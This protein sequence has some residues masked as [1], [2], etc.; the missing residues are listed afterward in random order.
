MKNVEQAEKMSNAPGFVAALDQSGGSTP[1]ALGLYGVDETQYVNNTQM[2]DLIHHMRCR[3]IQSAAFTGD[4][5]IGAILFENTIDREVSGLRVADFLWQEKQIVPFLKVDKGLAYKNKGVQLLKPMP[6]LDVLLMRAKAANIFGTKMRSVINHANLAGI[7]DIVEQQF[8]VANQILSHDLVPI[9]EPEV[10]ISSPDKAEAE[11]ML[12]ESL[13]L[14]LNDLKA[15]DKVILKL[16]LPDQ[17]NHYASLSSHA[18]IM[19]VMALSG[20]Y[21]RQEANTMLSQNVFMVASFSRAL[22]EG[23]N[24]SQ[25]DNDFDETLARTI[26][27]IFNASVSGS[28]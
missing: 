12:L 5:V 11:Q 15:R 23:L 1:K 6:E 4:H 25:S 26:H 27:E 19:R 14:H 13:A 24:A 22:S 28:S 16:T 10:D 20:G 18:N 7:T 8:E 2:Y 3:I 17:P 21:S 9:I